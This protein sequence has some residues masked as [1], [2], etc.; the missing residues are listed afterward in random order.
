M[1]EWSDDTVRALR[2]RENYLRK[3][4]RQDARR[5]ASAVIVGLGISTVLWAVLVIA[6]LL[7]LR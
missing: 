5:I 2:L 1:W 7:W 3:R 4:E 6:A